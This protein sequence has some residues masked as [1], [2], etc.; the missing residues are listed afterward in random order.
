MATEKKVTPEAQRKIV[1]EVAKRAK[2]GELEWADKAIRKVGYVDPDKLRAGDMLAVFG[3]GYS[4]ITKWR[5][6]G[7]PCEKASPRSKEAAYFALKDVIEWKIGRE[8]LTTADKSVYRE[9][10]LRIKAKSDAMDLAIKEGELQSRREVVEREIAMVS[11]VRRALI[12]M[13][14]KLAPRLVNQDAKGSAAVV[15][16]EVETV[17]RAFADG[18]GVEADE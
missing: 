10:I 12:G 7:C 11:E 14:S 9:E 2:S 17:I 16:A 5:S 18:L 15:R 6:L 3:V 1:E 13:A 8:R 4:T